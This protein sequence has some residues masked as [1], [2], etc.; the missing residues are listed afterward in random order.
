MKPNEHFADDSYYFVLSVSGIN[1]ANV[2]YISKPIYFKGYAD[3]NRN[4]STEFVDKAMRAFSDHLKA[5]YPDA[6][7]YGGLNN[8]IVMDRK[9]NST[10]EL[11]KSTEEVREKSNSW[12]ADQ[13]EKGYRVMLT[14]FSYSCN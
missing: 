7:P 9:V 10:S 6:F 14:S 4:K 1:A 12:I 13:K 8:I 5:T 3:C 11:L 2:G